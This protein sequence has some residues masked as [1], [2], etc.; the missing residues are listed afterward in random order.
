MYSSLQ[1]NSRHFDVGKSE[2][3]STVYL[4]E[5]KIF[6]DKVDRP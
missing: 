5:R 3:L 2:K 1:R 4:L 6:D